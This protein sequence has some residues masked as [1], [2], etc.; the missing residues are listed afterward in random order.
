LDFGTLFVGQSREL[1]LTVRNLGSA[2]LEVTSI[3]S[4]NSQ[5]TPGATAMTLAPRTSQRLVVTFHPGGA[6]V[7]QGTLRLQSN[8][9]DLPLVSIALAGTGLIPPDI[10]LTPTE[11]N[12]ALFT[13]QQTTQTLTIQNTGASDLTFTAAVVNPTANAVQHGQVRQMID[14]TPIAKGV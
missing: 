8:D 4:D 2:T 1:A 5:F 7:Y 9:P 3:A 11:L 10:A 13:G 14:A 12:A 6:G